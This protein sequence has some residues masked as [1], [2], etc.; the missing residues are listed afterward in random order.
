MLRSTPMDDGMRQ[1]LMDWFEAEGRDLPWRR[2]RRPWAILVSELMLQQTQVVRVLDRWPRFLDRFPDPEVCAAATVGELIEEW[3]GLGYNRR[4]VNLHRTAAVMVSEHAG[5]VPS[6]RARLLAMPGIGAYT[7]RAVQVFAFELDEAVVDTN[8][9]RVLA[10]VAGRPLT[11]AEVQRM[12]DGLVP[13]GRSW[14]WNQGLLDV[15]A[16]LCRARVRPSCDRCPLRDDC[17]WALA[18][19]PVPDPAVGSARVSTGQ[20]RFDGSDRQGRGRLVRRLG[21]GPLD[22][23]EAPSVM[24]WP[25]EPDRVIRVLSRLVADGLVAEEDGALRLPR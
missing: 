4:A 16:L 14:T 2:T 17:R 9:A 8:V 5:T 11:A 23:A 24:G 15:G 21:S 13:P 22:R 7:A 20:G 1:R 19:R 6:D 25:D 3:S 10:R 12:A 18:G